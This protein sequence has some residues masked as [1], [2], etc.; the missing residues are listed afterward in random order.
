LFWCLASPCVVCAYHLTLALSCAIAN[1]FCVTVLFESSCDM[2]HESGAK[3]KIK[4]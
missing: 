3:T 4:N 2:G 1:Y